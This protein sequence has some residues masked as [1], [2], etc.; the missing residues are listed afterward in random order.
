MGTTARLE[1]AR[2]HFP[3]TVEKLFSDESKFNWFGSDGVKWVRLPKSCR[4]NLKY[5]FPTIKY[6]GGNVMVCVGAC[7]R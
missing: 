5:T 2:D 7:R 1:F 4:L 3:L 6:G